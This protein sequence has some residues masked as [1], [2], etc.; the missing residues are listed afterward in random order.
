VDANPIRRFE[1]Y[2]SSQDYLSEVERAALSARAD[3]A[4]SDALRAADAA[5]TPDTC[6][7]EERLFER[8]LRDER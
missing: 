3:A 7:L 4:V 5:V 8:V 6:S 1:R 2:L